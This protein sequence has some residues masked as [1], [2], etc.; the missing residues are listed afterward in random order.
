M[1][2]A[3]VQTLTAAAKLFINFATVEIILAQYLQHVM[4]GENNCVSVT[5]GTRAVGI[6]VDKLISVKETMED[7]ANMPSVDTLEQI[8]LLANVVSATLVMGLLA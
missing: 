5:L 4:K 8:R 3:Q 2:F 6:I 1:R 7:A